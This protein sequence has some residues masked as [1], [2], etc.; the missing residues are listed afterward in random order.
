MKPRKL[1]RKL[2]VIYLALSMGMLV[3][4][5][6]CGYSEMSYFRMNP[7]DN[8]ESIEFYSD[9]LE[10]R[11]KEGI[12]LFNGNVSVT[13]GKNLLQTSKLAVYYDKMDKVVNRDQINT[14]I[15]SLTGFGSVNI[16]KM[17]AS[18][19]V[20]IKI[21]TQII[22]GDKGIFDGKSGMMI[23]AGND[24][25]FTDGDNVA[26]GCKLTANMKTGRAILEGCDTSNKKSRVSII[27]KQSKKNGY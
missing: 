20:Y 27:L 10:I 9:S 24:V 7:L 23:L 13:Q 6:A 17:E 19:K 21:A 18:G 26:T 12:A 3:P 1:H 5:V 14:R 25:V 2:V 22:T 11:D 4:K 15:V 8:K 16:K